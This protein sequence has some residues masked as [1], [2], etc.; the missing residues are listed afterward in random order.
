MQ[1]LLQCYCNFLFTIISCLKIALSLLY[2]GK[3]MNK[4]LYIN[5]II[6]VNQ[7]L[8]NKPLTDKICDELWD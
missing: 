7:L 1:C 5:M 4:Y 6:M 8:C 2:Y 3:I